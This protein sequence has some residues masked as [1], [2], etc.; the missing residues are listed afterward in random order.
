MTQFYSAEHLAQLADGFVNLSGRCMAIQERCLTRRFSNDRAKEFAQQGFARRLSTLARCM[1]NAFSALP[2]D[3]EG[4]PSDDDTHNA[5]IQLQAFVINVF[6]CLDNLAWVWV[7]E[8]DLKRPNG[9]EIP[10]EWVGLR[11]PNTF[12]RESFSPAFQAYLDS[13]APWFAYQEGYRHALAHQIPLYIPPYAVAPEN[14]SRYHELEDGITRAVMRGDHVGAES[15]RQEC[16]KLKFFRP[17]IMHSWTNATP[18]AFHPQMIADFRTIEEIG[19]RVFDEL[20]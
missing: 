1:K 4:V 11:P 13:L 15:R 2:P 20:A 7:L 18:L 16:D 8:R 3:L 12:V 19:T 6:G 5:A 14:M 10:P 17:F 9:S